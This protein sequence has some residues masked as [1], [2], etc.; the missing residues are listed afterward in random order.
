VNQIPE[1]K[2]EFLYLGQDTK[3]RISRV[4]GVTKSITEFLAE[5]VE[6][7]K[8]LHF[9]EAIKQAVPWAEPALGAATETIGE[10]LP[11]VKFLVKLAQKITEIND[12]E[13]L[14]HLACTI[15][16]ERATEQA[17]R[18]V[19]GPVEEKHA[20][21]EVKEQLA[22]LEPS[23]DVDLGAFTYESALD[24]EFFKRAELNLQTALLIVG[25]N[26]PQVD[27]ITNEVKDRFVVCLRTLLSQRNTA[28]K[29]TPFKEYIELGGAKE[30]QAYKALTDHGRYQRWLFEE[31]PVLGKSPFALQ[32]IYV[33]TDCGRLAWEEINPPEKRPGTPRSV[34]IQNPDQKI[35]PFSEQFGGRSSLLKTVMDL[36]GDPQFREPII[37][38]GAAGSGK[39]SLTLRLCVELMRHQLRPIRVRCKDLRFDKHIKEALPQ[40]VKLSDDQRSPNGIPPIPEDVFRGGN[41]F[42]ENGSGEYSKICRYV[43]IL[44]GWDEISVANEGF[45]RRIV[46]MLEQLRNEYLDNPT[47][48]LPIRV[49]LTGR[50][51]ADVTESGFLRDKTPILTIRPLSPKQL[52]I[53]IKKLH[54]T[55][56]APPLHPPEEDKW[57][58]FNLQKFMPIISRYKS[59]FEHSSDISQYRRN[60]VRYHYSASNSVT[61]SLGVLG[62]PLLAQLAARLISVWEQDPEQLVNN[63][64]TLYRNL[65]NLTCEKGGKAET[66]SDA[67]DEIRTQARIMGYELRDLLWQTATAMT[68]YGKDLIPYE[69]LSKRLHF[70]GEELDEQVNIA[71]GKH[72]LSALLISFYF[73]GGVKHLGCEFIHKSFRE[74]LFA[75]AIVEA[76]KRFAIESQG[77]LSEREKYWKDFSNE[78]PRY[79]F[80]RELSRLLAPQW[81]SPEVSSHLTQL[82]GWE[83]ERATS[84]ARKNEAG[85]VTDPLSVDDWR[86]VRDGLADLWDWWGE[87]VHLRSQPQWGKRRELT[88][89]PPYVTELIEYSLP[90]DSSSIE[91]PPPRTTTLDAHLGNGLFNLCVLVHDNLLSIDPAAPNNLGSQV[92]YAEEQ[93]AVR[94]YQTHKDVIRFAP[95]GKD[96]KY[97]GNYIHRINS[98]G[99]RPYGP[100]PSFTSLRGVDLTSIPLSHNSFESVDFY[101]AILE[102]ADLSGANLESAALEDSILD[103]AKLEGANLSRASLEGAR[104]KRVDLTM[105]DLRGANFDSAVLHEANLGG[106]DLRGA[107]LTS[108]E[109]NKANL[110]EANLVEA[111]LDHT[112]LDETKFDKAILDKADLEKA[113]IR[114]TSFKETSLNSTDFTDV[115]LSTAIGLTARQIDVAIV[116]AKTKLPPI[117]LDLMVATALRGIPVA[118]RSPQ[119]QREW[120]PD[121]EAYIEA[122]MEAEK[123]EKEEEEEKDNAS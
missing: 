81:L 66:D 58:K 63:P 2:K 77:L 52:Q 11:P 59:E 86:R 117:Q 67:T 8:S 57:P 85:T 29:F 101:G 34:D 80:S 95:S 5:A 64:T 113:K 3:R 96:G 83:I 16:F 123:K 50:P 107:V 26:G 60:Y 42:R 10:I 116:S 39:S 90:F 38:Q 14:G 49:I 15:A 92:E 37:I 47:L 44:D 4:S 17:I 33:E 1:D 121:I 91:L 12:P 102:R 112:T 6:K 31:A 23:E 65:V 20:T 76:L 28:D 89:L 53:F 105:A 115:D 122:Q 87:G 56:E 78:D 119:T 75:E 100:F 69:E 41:I 48:P 93:G 108:A 94:T 110:R 13:E 73:K 98:A 71:T 21:K 79:Q 7:T 22:L 25:Y 30:R 55:I 32:H 40:A 54:H 70:E 61:G 82:I 27:Q 111:S 74:Y 84:K 62:L 104:L 109:L 9:P 99:W 97:F 36:I 120:D 35:D 46:Q 18:I 19:G 72:S 114:R 103:G 106:A 118:P 45:R 51:S 24:H 68:I 88:Y 43:L